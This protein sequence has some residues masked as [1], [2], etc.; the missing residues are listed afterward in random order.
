MCTSIIPKESLQTLSKLIS[1][2]KKVSGILVVTSKRTGKDQTYKIKGY[3]SNRYG[4]SVII[5]YEKGYMDFVGCSYRSVSNTA[6]LFSKFCNTKSNVVLGAQ[7]ILNKLIKGD[8]DKLVEVST[9]SHIGSCIKC[10]RPLTD[11][12]SIDLGLGPICRNY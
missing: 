6:N 9:I 11:A 4:Y 8:I 10:N 5:S 12:E 1:D 2:Q 7:F 3:N